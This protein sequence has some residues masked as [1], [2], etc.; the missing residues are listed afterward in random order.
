MYKNKAF[1]RDLREYCRTCPEALY[2]ALNLKDESLAMGWLVYEQSVLDELYAPWW[3]EL[4]CLEQALW[5][6]KGVAKYGK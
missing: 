1:M 2:E 6:R 3:S 4:D 5:V